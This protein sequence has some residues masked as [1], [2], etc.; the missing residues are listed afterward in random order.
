[1]ASLA[2]ATACGDRSRGPGHREQVDL[3]P[4]VDFD[5]DACR[6]HV[7]AV[8]PRAGVLA[9]S[10]TTGDGLTGWYDWLAGRSGG[11]SAHLA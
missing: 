7:R 2:L 9:L 8:N 1:V 10:A 3:L 5:L 4:Y 11:R 6:R